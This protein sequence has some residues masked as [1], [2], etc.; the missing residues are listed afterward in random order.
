M[1]GSVTNIKGN[2]RD[3]RVL[4]VLSAAQYMPTREKL[5]TL[6]D[7]YEEDESIHVYA[8]AEDGVVGGVIVVKHLDGVAYEIISIAVDNARRGRGIGSELIAHAVKELKCL[9]LY[10]ETDDDAVGFY[11]K[12]GFAIT[13]L[14][15]KYEGVIR[16]A[17]IL[18]ISELTR[19]TF[20]S[21][22]GL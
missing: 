22:Y 3:E 14:G 2:L 7:R 19:Q 13:S 4:R 9:S 15:E 11:R 12:N 1:I 17:C 5:C 16:Y 18:N 6:A 21:R 10:A 20:F 8:Y